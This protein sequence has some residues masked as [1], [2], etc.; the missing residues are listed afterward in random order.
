M[1]GHTG[2]TNFPTTSGALTGTFQGGTDD[3]YIASIDF[4][5]SSNPNGQLRFS[6]YFGGNDFEQVRDVALDSQGNIYVTG[7][8][9]SKNLPT[10]SG[11]FQPSFRGGPM[12]AFVAKFSSTGQMVFCTYLGGSVYDVGY[13]IAVDAAGFIYVSGRTS[14][15][16]F[17]VTSGAF[18]T[19]YAGGRST[20]APYLGGDVF[21]V[22][23]KPDGSGIVWGT[24]VGG[25]SDDAARGR[26]VLDA[27]G[28]VYVEGVTDSSNFPTT[29]NAPQR[30]L[31]GSQDAFVFKL[32]PDGSQLLYSTYLG[33]NESQGEGAFGGI[34]VNGQGE[35]Y[36]CGSTTAADFPATAG[37]Q[38]RTLSGQSD[39]FLA[40]LGANGN[41]IAATLLGGSADEDCQGLVLDSAGRPV[42]FGSTNSSNFP[43]TASAYQRAFAGGAHDFTLTKL[44][45]DLSSIIFSTYIGGSGN[46][47][48][49]TA[50]VDVDASDN[51]VLVGVTSSSAFPVTSGAVQSTYA[52]GVEDS[53]LIKLSAD[54]SR[55]LFATYLGGNG[56]DYARSIRYRPN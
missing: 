24:Y 11:A 29:S 15:P 52:G 32:S 18:Q 49:D 17:P 44:S 5:T 4:P 43:T 40:R 6:T 26:L 27:S 36:V 31:H 12:D 37:A 51:V 53:V 3:G 35:A 34:A 14:S 19:T 23:M 45:A 2:S 33:G 28:A 22:K 25:S 10:T 50:R 21:V 41:L 48:G 8:V 42:V 1:V 56:D 38:N 46:E 16:D 20:L 47:G 54:G 30:V 7:R 55:I 9:F 39:I 13:S